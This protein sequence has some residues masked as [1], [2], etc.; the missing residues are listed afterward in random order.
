MLFRWTVLMA[1]HG[2]SNRHSLGSTP[3]LVGLFASGLL[4]AYRYGL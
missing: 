3:S 2:S 1:L 4:S